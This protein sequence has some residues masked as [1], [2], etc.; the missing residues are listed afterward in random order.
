MRIIRNVIN[1][2]QALKM[3]HTTMLTY[4]TN[5]LKKKWGRE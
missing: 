5:E 2:S 4:N 1:A 3:M